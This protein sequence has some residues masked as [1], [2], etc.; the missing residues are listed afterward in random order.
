MNA[1]LESP[2]AGTPPATSG[3]VCFED[4]NAASFQHPL[5]RQAT[6]RLQGLRGFDLVMRKFLEFGYERLAYVLNIATSVRISDVQ[7]PM[8]HNM[9][10]ASCEVLDVAEPELYVAESQIINAYTFGSTRPYIVVNS[11]LLDALGDDEVLAVIAHEVGHIK[12]GQVL[13]KS[14]ATAV[15]A[16]ATSLGQYSLGLTELMTRP[17]EFALLEW[18]RRSELSADRASLLVTQDRRS[19]LSTLMKLAGGGSRFDHHLN[20]EAFLDQAETYTEGLDRST[21]DRVYRFL[22]GAKRGTH[23]FAV[24]RAK[25]AFEWLSS[26]QYS[27]ILAGKYIRST[28]N[29]P[30]SDRCPTC[31][32]FAGSGHLFCGNCGQP[33]RAG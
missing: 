16:L 13:Y 22:A 23:P 1:G 8:L 5:D 18:D 7:L 30:A 10:L 15:S 28:A 25:A 11:G 20:L 32:D 2:L 31:N 19:T 29:T 33:L 9:L 4:L 27:D 21:S 14:M 17:I 12:C 3:R 24:E 26:S 6:A